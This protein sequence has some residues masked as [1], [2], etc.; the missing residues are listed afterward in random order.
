M[1]QEIKNK[2]DEQALKIDAIYISVEKSRKYFLVTMWVTILAI[3]VP[4]LLV[5]IIAPSFVNSYTEALNVS[6]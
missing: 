4:M 5:G 2:L 3:V 1:D 6:Q